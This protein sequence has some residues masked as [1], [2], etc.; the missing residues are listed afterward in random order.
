MD[1]DDVVDVL[2]T[3]IETSKD[4]EYGFRTSAERAEEPELKASFQRRAQACADG[5]AE[6]QGLVAHYGGKPADSG[7]VLGAMHRGWVSLKD[8][9]ASRDDLSILEECERG[10]DVAKA[11]YL[12]ALQSNDLPDNVREVVVRQL[13]G[14]ERNHDEVKALRDAHRQSRA[15]GS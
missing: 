4:G 8:A 1:N 15:V 7:T 13:N 2:N 6:L 5:V 12:K 14:V 3:L 10:E 9:V 11:R